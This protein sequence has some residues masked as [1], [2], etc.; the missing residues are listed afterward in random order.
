MILIG[1]GSA[2]EIKALSEKRDDTA[3]GQN[4]A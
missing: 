1:V 4:P 3:D 2:G